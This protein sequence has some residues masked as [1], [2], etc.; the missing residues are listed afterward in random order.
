MSMA[1]CKNKDI[2]I[3]QQ[4]RNVVKKRKERK[5]GWPNKIDPLCNLF[6]CI[7]LDGSILFGEMCPNKTNPFRLESPNRDNLIKKHR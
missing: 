7:Q 5:T 6:G 1:D 2:S 4:K 3:S